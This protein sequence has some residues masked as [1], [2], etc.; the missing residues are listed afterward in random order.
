MTFIWYSYVSIHF[1]T[2]SCNHL[3]TI[4]QYN[5]PGINEIFFFFDDDDDFTNLDFI[6]YKKSLF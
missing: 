5:G 2:V 4:I 6:K 1:S 3:F